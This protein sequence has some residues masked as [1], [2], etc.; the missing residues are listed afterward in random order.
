MTRKYTIHSDQ[1]KL[2][3]A[4]EALKGNK[5]VPDYH[6]KPLGNQDVELMNE[7]RDIKVMGLSAA[8]DEL[9]IQMSL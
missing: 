1:F 5:T 6:K 8:E 3:V 2:K 7:I 4:L 9:F